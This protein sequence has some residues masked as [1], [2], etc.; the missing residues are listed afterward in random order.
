MKI[1]TID[2]VNRE[3]ANDLVW[4]KKELSTLKLV[5]ERQKSPASLRIHVVAGEI[6]ELRFTQ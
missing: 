5:I 1:R 3:L 6:E 2:D 4:R